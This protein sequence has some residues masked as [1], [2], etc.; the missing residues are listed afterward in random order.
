[1]GGS[2]GRGVYNSIL[3]NG[4]STKSIGQGFSTGFKNAFDF[5]GGWT[6]AGAGLGMNAAGAILSAVGGPK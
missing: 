6:S 1:L 5:K 2:I 3:N 4:L